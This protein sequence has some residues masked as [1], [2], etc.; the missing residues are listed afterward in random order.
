MPLGREVASAEHAL[1]RERL[2]SG[3]EEC[4]QPCPGRRDLV[5]DSALALPTSPE[6]GQHQQIVLNR[7]LAA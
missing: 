2:V 1:S 5:V 7:I 4:D 3:D 6:V